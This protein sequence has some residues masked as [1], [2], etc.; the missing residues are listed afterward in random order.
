MKYWSRTLGTFFIEKNFGENTFEKNISG[1][2]WEKRQPKRS[3]KKIWEK[4]S[5]KTKGQ[6]F[7]DRNVSAKTTKTCEK[8]QLFKLSQFQGCE[9][10]NGKKMNNNQKKN[11]C[12]ATVVV[13]SAVLMV[14]GNTKIA[15]TIFSLQYTPPRT[16][17]FHLVK[18]VSPKSKNP[19]EKLIL[20]NFLKYKNQKN[21]E[22]DFVLW[23]RT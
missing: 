19:G 21:P 6:N 17:N 18:N 16:T 5:G 2:D 15:K 23:P 8:T 4:A 22:G 1:K 10:C 11:I 14:I 7:E 20:Q 9:Q 3:R 12:G 13:P